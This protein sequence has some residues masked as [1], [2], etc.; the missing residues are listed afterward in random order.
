[1]NL[2]IKRQ[3]TKNFEKHKGEIFPLL[4]R[5]IDFDDTQIRGYVNGTIYVLLQMQSF[6]QEAIK[7]KL[8]NIVQDL[9]TKYSLKLQEVEEEDLDIDPDDYGIVIRQ[10]KYIL[11][12]MEEEAETESQIYQ[13]SDD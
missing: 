13:F 5:Y 7:H 3:S 11:E 9:H 6:R 8:C 10:Y 2:A 12:R 4:L 1:M